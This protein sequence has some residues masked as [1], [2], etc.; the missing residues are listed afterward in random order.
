MKVDIAL[1]GAPVRVSRR[2]SDRAR[3]P[4]PPRARH[5]SQLPR[6]RL[7]GLNHHDFVSKK[8]TRQPRLGLSECG[9]RLWS[10]FA[11]MVPAA[12]VECVLVAC[13]RLMARPPAGKAFFFL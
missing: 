2:D 5:A 8:Y 1:F 3:V 6:I 10:P 11:A 13:E 9:N 12:P 7:S 4:A